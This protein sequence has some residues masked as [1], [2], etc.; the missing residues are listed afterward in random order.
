LVIVAA[1]PLAGCAGANTSAR[2]FKGTER[3]VA[4]AIGS[5]ESAGQRKNQQKICQDLL[6]AQYARSLAAAGS[7]CEDEVDD[8]MADAD[9]YKLTVKSVTVSGPAATAQVENAGRTF[10]MRL[11]RVGADWRI[12][13]L[14]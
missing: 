4:D 14:G 5:F 9:D 13:S 6:T 8:A 2:N 10:T 7:T 12:A 1:V 3:D 11:Q